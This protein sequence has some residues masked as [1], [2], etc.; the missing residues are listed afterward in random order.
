MKKGIYDKN[1]LLT[2]KEITG[3]GKKY[4]LFTFE[5]GPV[6]DSYTEAFLF[7]HN[8]DVSVDVVETFGD[9]IEKLNNNG[10]VIEDINLGLNFS[11]FAD[12]DSLNE[13]G[14]FTGEPSIYDDKVS[15]MI[16]NISGHYSFGGEESDTKPFSV[17]ARDKGT[18]VL[19]GHL[20]IT[21][22][23]DFVIG[24]N[25]IGFE[26]EGIS[27]FNDVKTKILNGEK[28]EGMVSLTTEK[29]KVYKKS[30]K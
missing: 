14:Y 25:K 30:E 24:L 27:S 12:I 23:S 3:R 22:F 4:T 10:R 15:V 21:N 1:S 7:R 9:V 2:F 8:D 19:D 6:W 5:D 20:F 28:A 26:L 18:E 16:D 13:E 11:I 29:E 17:V